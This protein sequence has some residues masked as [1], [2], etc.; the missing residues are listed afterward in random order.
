MLLILATSSLLGSSAIQAQQ[1]VET[2]T[3]PAVAQTLVGTVERLGQD[4]GYI[5][6]SGRNYG[7]D[8]ELTQVFLDDEPL[9]SGF[10]DNGMSVRIAIDS[11]AVLLR[12][13][14]LGPFSQTRLLQEH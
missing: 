12:I 10:L 7:Y 4:S 2:V 8:S 9:D 1:A 14:V 11:N 6:I 3:R 5:T 13:D